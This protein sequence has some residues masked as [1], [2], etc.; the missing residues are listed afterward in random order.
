M[1]VR[2]RFNGNIVGLGCKLSS[3]PKRRTKDAEKVVKPARPRLEK[4]VGPV[5]AAQVMARHEGSMVGRGSR[6]F[7]WGEVESSGIAMGTAKG[8]G[9][10]L[11]IRR[12]SVLEENVGALKTWYSKAR[13]VERPTETKKLEKEIEKIGKEA[14]KEVKKG[15]AKVKREAVKVAK[16]AEKVEKEAAE[17]V[18][19][20]VKTRRSRKKTAESS[21]KKEG[22]SQK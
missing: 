9:L 15:A 16:E 2:N 14:E 10:P 22:R 18:E 20:P 4:P 13:Q 3:R 8:W 1:G 6:G 12:R 7:S 11:D 19:E 17:K 21:K 5:P